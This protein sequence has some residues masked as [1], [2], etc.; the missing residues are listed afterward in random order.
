MRKSKDIWKMKDGTIQTFDCG[1]IPKKG[2][3]LWVGY[4]YKKQCW[5]EFGEDIKNLKKWK[6]IKT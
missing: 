6:K 5:V 4:N 3:K 1:F 2:L